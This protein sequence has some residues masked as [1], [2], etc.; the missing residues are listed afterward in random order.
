[1]FCMLVCPPFPSPCIPS[2]LP[3]PVSFRISPTTSSSFFPRF[4]LPSSIL[5]EGEERCTGPARVEP[6]RAN[7]REANRVEFLGTD[8]SYVCNTISIGAQGRRPASEGGDDLQMTYSFSWILSDELSEEELQKRRLDGEPGAKMVRFIPF[9]FRCLVLSSYDESDG[10]LWT[11]GS[12]G[13][14]FKH[15]SDEGDGEGWEDWLVSTRT[16]DTAP[17]D[18]MR[19][20]GQLYIVRNE[21]TR[22]EKTPS[23]SLHKARY[24]HDQ[25]ITAIR[26]LSS[27]SI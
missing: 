2:S 27:S 1:M 17:E 5:L 12:I 6:N 19:H 11:D 21:T 4:S 14:R 9:S 18:T 22:S 3:F 26:H 23:T 7:T 15:P 16:N 25:L 13:G 24:M 20:V 10:L 8:G